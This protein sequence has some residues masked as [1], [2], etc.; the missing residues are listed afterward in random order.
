MSELVLSQTQEQGRVALLTL[1]RHSKRNALNT[2][3]CQAL[4][5]SLNE[6]VEYGARA[7]VLTGDGT[8]F[9][10]GADLSGDASTEDLFPALLSM[11]DAIRTLPV[12]VVAAVNGPAIGAGTMLAMAC[13]LRVVDEAA[14]FRVPVV[15]VAI[16]LDST[17]VRTLE[18]LV[19][20]ARARSMLLT[21]ATLDIDAAV[22]SGFAYS[23]GPLDEALKLGALCATKAPLTVAQLKKEFAHSSGSPFSA[24]ELAAAQQ[25]AWQSEDLLESRR[26]REEKRAPDFQ[27]R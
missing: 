1:N 5:Q 24:E 9:S 3:M 17:T 2:A 26:A 6:A 15:D 16:A 11:L 10:A 8:V 7:V 27:G 23:R 18:L 25:A 20:G 13:D 21:G 14:Y 12:P 19:G 22:D 4:E